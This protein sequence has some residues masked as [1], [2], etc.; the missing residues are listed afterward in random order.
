V[1]GSF[2]EEV[3]RAD[4]YL[5]KA[6]LHDWPDDQCVEILRT[7][8]RSL[9]PGGVVLVVETVVGR[10]GFE[11][12]AAFSDLNMLVMPGGRERTE[13][14]YGVLFAAAGLTLARV[15]DTPTRF[16]VLEGRAAVS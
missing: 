16:S 14:E 8:A 2:F 3:P 9:H 5:L 11:V 1:A 15:V 12:E 13:H 4:G 10:P 7:C 6:I